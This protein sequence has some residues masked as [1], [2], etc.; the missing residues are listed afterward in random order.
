MWALSSFGAIFKINLTLLAVIFTQMEQ[1]GLYS[2]MTDKGSEHMLDVSGIVY[3]W[4]GTLQFSFRVK[5]IF[6]P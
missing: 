6:Q 4:Q 2:M 1:I 3:N 5:T